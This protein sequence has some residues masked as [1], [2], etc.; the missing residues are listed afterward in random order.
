MSK[1]NPKLYLEDI[2]EAIDKIEKYTS[3]LSFEEFVQNIM[4]IDAVIRN[5]T[6]IGEAAKNIPEKVKMENPD[7]LWNEAIGMRNKAIHEYFGIDEEILWKTIEEDLPI[8]R[9]QILGLI[10]KP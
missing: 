10:E 9:K 3:D 8:F 2:K 1:R 6:V 5:L 7:V 4:A